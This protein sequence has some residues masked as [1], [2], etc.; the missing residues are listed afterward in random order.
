MARVINYCFASTLAA[1]EWRG[2]ASAWTGREWSGACTPLLRRL[3]TDSAV[4]A[5]AVAVALDIGL[6]ISFTRLMKLDSEWSAASSPDTALFA[7]RATTHWAHQHKR[8]LQTDPN[9]SPPQNTMP[10]Q[11]KKQQ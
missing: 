10:K 2:G 11:H 1:T 9:F 6:R 3:V 4:A 5:A 8:V 7:A